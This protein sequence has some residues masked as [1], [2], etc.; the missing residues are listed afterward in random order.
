MGRTLAIQGFLA[1]PRMDGDANGLIRKYEFQVS[2][3]GSRWTT[4]AAADWLPYCTEVDFP[5]QSCR[6][7]RLVSTEGAFASLAEIDV[8][9]A[10]ADY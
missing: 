4:V 6:Y 5:A 10:S 9:N 7:F 2:Q 8:I 3:D 1:T